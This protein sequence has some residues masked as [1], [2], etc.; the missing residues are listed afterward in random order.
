MSLS[1]L[2]GVTVLRLWRLSTV[3]A[4]GSITLLCTLVLETDAG[5]V[6]LFSGQEGV[7][8]R[9]PEPRQEIRWETEPELAMGASAG[10]EEWLDLAPVGEALSTTV[11]SVRTLTGVGSYT[12]TFALFLGELAIAVTDEFDLECLPRKEVRRRAETLTA[13]LGLRLVESEL[14]AV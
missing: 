11:T 10:A 3:S 8:C 5:F 13:A 9:G 4:E 14:H 1:A 7:S 6:T 2:L 12:L